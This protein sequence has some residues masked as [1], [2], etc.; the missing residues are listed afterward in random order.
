MLSEASVVGGLSPLQLQ[1]SLPNYLGVWS[2]WPDSMVH[3]QTLAL[4]LPDQP[5]DFLAG[6]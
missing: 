1:E 6:I 4:L 3:I 5:Q 2:H